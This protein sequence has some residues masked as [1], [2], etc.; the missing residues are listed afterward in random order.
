MSIS[1]LIYMM[2][3]SYYYNYI[4]T[5]RY[6]L[7]FIKIYNILLLFEMVNLV[8]KFYLVSLII[9]WK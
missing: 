1:D 3:G 2:D 9:N 8:L 6:K 7:Y 4:I 5:D